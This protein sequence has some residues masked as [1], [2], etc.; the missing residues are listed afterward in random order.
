MELYFTIWEMKRMVSFMC[1]K[2]EDNKTTHSKS[3]EMALMLFTST[4]GCAFHKHRW[5][6]ERVN[7]SMPRP[8]RWV[9]GIVRQQFITQ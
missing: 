4:G 9:D 1:F 2:A 7:T 5:V 6:C 8:T 3:V